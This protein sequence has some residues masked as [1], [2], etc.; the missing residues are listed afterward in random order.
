MDTT[1][2]VSIQAAIMITRLIILGSGHCVCHEHKSTIGM[3]SYIYDTFAYYTE[4]AAGINK[5]HTAPNQHIRCPP[6]YNLRRSAVWIYM[7]QS[8]VINRVFQPSVPS[9]E[10]LLPS[11]LY[12]QL[13]CQEQLSATQEQVN[14][15]FFSKQIPISSCDILLP[16]ACI[17]KFLFSHA[18]K[19]HKLGNYLS[20][21]H[22]NAC[23]IPQEFS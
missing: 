5:T 20:V 7:V 18:F 15:C 14:F 6:G 8:R 4:S 22:Y 1:P 10:L 19:I 13:L 11:K 16:Q 12:R 21:F 9:A 3:G 23:R 17:H 2:P